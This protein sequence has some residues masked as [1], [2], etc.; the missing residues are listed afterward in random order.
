[1]NCFY[2]MC[3]FVT[4]GW[5]DQPPE[6]DGWETEG[7]DARPGGG[8]RPHFYILSSVWLNGPQY[9]AA[10]ANVAIKSNALNR[11]QPGEVY[12]L[13]LEM[14]KGRKMHFSG[15]RQHLK[16]IGPHCL[17][18]IICIWTAVQNGRGFS[19]CSYTSVTVADRQTKTF[20]LSDSVV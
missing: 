1:M 7:A 6:P 14:N 18:I 11:A 10:P 16:N 5:R 17:I 20:K 12:Y 3:P 19:G 15:A 4:E 9:A 8:K 2:S 13:A